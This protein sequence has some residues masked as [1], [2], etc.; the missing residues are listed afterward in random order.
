M[1]SLYISRVVIKN[2][3]NFKDVDVELGHKAIV[4]GENNV[5]KTNFLR[6]L[7]LILDSTLSDD[8]RMLDESDFNDTLENPM[9]NEEEIE[10]QIYISNYQ[11]NR[12][13]LT[14]LQDAT[15]KDS[16]GIEVLKLTYKF[17]PY[18][19]DNGNTEYIYKIF[20]GDKEDKTFGAYERKYLN[21][22]VI[23]ALRDVEGEMKNSRLS[24]V[25]KMLD[26]YSIEKE[27]LV[28]IAEAYKESGEK[29]LN[30]D[31]L[32]DLT[33]NINRRFSTI[34]GNKDFD[35]SLQAMEIDPTKV[36]SSLKL[37]M[38]N[39][40]A[41]DTSLGVNNI[42]Y[43][44][45]VLQMLQDKTVPTFMKKEDYDNLLS[46]DNSK[47]LKE[48]YVA[49]VS[50]NYFLK[51]DI[52]EEK[53]KEIYA[54][55]SKNCLSS[56]GVTILAI[57]EPEAHLHPIYQ[58]LIYRDVIKNSTNSVLLT[59]HSTNITA[60]APINSIVHLH[61]EKNE[62]T[63]IHATANMPMQDEEF[64]DVERYLD[65]KRGEIYLGKAV[66]LVEGIAEEYLVP[67]FAEILGKPLD[68]KG[69]IV[70][71]INSTNFTPYVKMLRSLEI[72]YAIITDGDF[73][74]IPENSDEREYHLMDTE[75]QKNDTWGYLGYEIIK[76]MVE[77]LKINGSKEIPSEMDEQNQ[78]FQSYGIFI[79][80]YTLEVHIMQACHGNAE[81]TQVLIDLFNELTT[82]GAT[83][84]KNFKNELQGEKYWKCLSKIEGNGIGK[85]RFAQKLIGKCRKEFIPAY[86]ENAINYIYKKVDE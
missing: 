45:M 58:R 50:G 74:R 56:K 69:I 39:R 44:S 61:A 52:S 82:G 59:T 34:L 29:I 53:K 14:V 33:Q 20:Q 41:A 75:V 81:A 60:I 1:Q 32:V 79:S 26:E 5:G 73:Y 64:L 24:P 11:S 10:I 85:G 7:Q 35:V 40:N 12:T 25:K 18:T 63:K 19:D 57:E 86:I 27:Q 77:E 30:L 36:L 66:I 13:I 55:M 70:C 2:Y 49:N 9:E 76:R 43:I 6:A 54:F 3:R 65:V 37:L 15:V 78:L 71:N 23:K 8:D 4:I 38:A 67:K 72:P 48:V 51:E 68:E 21:L 80:E 17:M 47:I 83:Q 22:K 28:R 31:E 16:N 46:K 42:L 84:K 62:G